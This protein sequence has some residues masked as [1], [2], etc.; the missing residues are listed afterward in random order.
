[1]VTNS[2]QYCT[3]HAARV[4]MDNIK[5]VLAGV[6]LGAFIAALSY[7]IGFACGQPKERKLAPLPPVSLCGHSTCTNEEIIRTQHPEF[8]P[9]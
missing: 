3:A 8:F 5:R 4:T 1:M 9:T 6:A 7:F 2:Q